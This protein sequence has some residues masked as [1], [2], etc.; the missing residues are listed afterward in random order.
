[1]KMRKIVAIVAAVLMLLS[2]MPIAAFAADTYEL[3]TSIEVGDTV[4]LVCKDKSM[5]LN[6]ISTT[7][8]KYGLGVAYTTAPAG[9]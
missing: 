1:M 8:T 3:A 9:A 7:S 5:E 2:V 6:G 4:V